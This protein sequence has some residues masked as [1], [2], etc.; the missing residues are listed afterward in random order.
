MQNIEGSVECEYDTE[1]G[2][3]FDLEIKYS[4]VPYTPARITRDPL[5]SEPAEGGYCEDMIF[6]VI[7]YRQYYEDGNT[8][9]DLPLRKLT[10]E[11]TKEFTIKF[12]KLVEKENLFYGHFHELCVQDVEDREPDYD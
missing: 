8:I 12:E 6:T 9:L 11:Q 3:A 7:G 10:L 2:E 5:D 4:Y 1:E